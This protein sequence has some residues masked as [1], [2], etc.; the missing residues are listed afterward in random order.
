MF[1]LRQV[2]GRSLVRSGHG[3]CLYVPIRLGGQ[4]EI[5]MG[6]RNAFGYRKGPRLGNGEILL[7]ARRP[8]AVICIGSGNSFSNNVS[9]IANKAV[10]IGQQ[11]LIGD[12]VSI[13][14]SDFHETD[15]TR[16][17]LGSGKENPVTIGNNVWLGSRV[18]VMKGVCIG[19]NTVVGAMSL[20]TR[21]LPANCI[22]GGNPATIIRRLD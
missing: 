5:R 11:C 14:D 6:D 7:Q 9:I 4:G 13:Y 1:K 2:F 10:S 17:R 22:A 16:R 8:S 15:P 18:I 19:D 21:S 3:N 20:V 12:Q